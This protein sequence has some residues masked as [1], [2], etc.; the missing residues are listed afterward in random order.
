MVSFWPR[1][2]NAASRLLDPPAPR[3]PPSPLRP[4]TDPVT[5]SISTTYP[6]APIPC[7]N[8]FPFRKSPAIK[9]LSRRP[10]STS[11]APDSF[12]TAQLSNRYRKQYSLG[13]ALST[14]NWFIVPPKL[15]SW[16]FSC[17]TKARRAGAYGNGVAALSA[18]WSPLR[19]PRGRCACRLAA[20]TAHRLSG[21]VQKRTPRRQELTSPYT[22]AQLIVLLYVSRPCRLQ[23]NERE[24][25]HRRPAAEDRTDSAQ[26][27]DFL[28]TGARA[29][30][31]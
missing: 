29:H 23:C 11:G 13:R 17:V 4:V 30:H 22:R 18:R 7:I 26:L 6:N 10:G 16:G 12:V 5:P 3:Q 9:I 27:I 14:T 21:G 20:D 28:K 15:I 31:V 1:P 24:S 19:E 8:H 25:R 2:R